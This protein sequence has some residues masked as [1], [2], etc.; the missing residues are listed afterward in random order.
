MRLPTEGMSRAE[1]V[2]CA[3]ARMVVEL[4]DG[5]T[6][7]LVRW[8]TE[9]RPGTARVETRPGKSI[10]VRLPRVRAVLLGHADH[11]HPPAKGL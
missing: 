9:A 10:T 8:D 6:G 3:K 11:D 5:S 2:R 7:R 4:D 1:L